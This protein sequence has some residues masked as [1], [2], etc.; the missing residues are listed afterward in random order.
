[1][2]LFYENMIPWFFSTNKH[3][4]WAP[5]RLLRRCNFSLGKWPTFFV[6]VPHPGWDVGKEGKWWCVIMKLYLLIN[7]IIGV[8]FKLRKKKKKYYLIVP[9]GNL[10]HSYGLNHHFS[11]ENPLLMVIFNSYVWH[12]Q[13]VAPTGSPSE[14]M[15]IA[16][17]NSSGSPRKSHWHKPTDRDKPLANPTMVICW[18]YHH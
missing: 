6:G 16:F 8:Y 13:R 2:V 11:W 10:P 4:L 18:W 14:K 3:N 5:G 15:W 17:S 1:M 7:Q 12:N 9:S